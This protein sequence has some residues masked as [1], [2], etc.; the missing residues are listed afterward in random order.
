MP[1]IV[2]ASSKGGSGKSTTVFAL[3]GAFVEQGLSVRIVDADRAARLVDCASGG[4]LPDSVTV[5][6]A[7]ENNVDAA[8]KEGRGQADIVLVDVEGS[9]NAAILTAVGFAN[10]VVVPA[11]PSA[12]DVAAALETVKLI[13][14]VGSMRERPVNFGLLWTR[15]PT[16]HSKEIAAQEEDI[17]DADIPILGRLY[18]RTAYKSLFSYQRLLQD[19]GAAA[20]NLIKT[21]AEVDLVANTIL[22]AMEAGATAQGAAA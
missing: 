20:P 7:D 21:K 1:V 17:R 10:Y 11:N 16:T 14:R 22:D 8:I 19:L 13:R 3:T 4:N 6:A 2:V 12:M 9:A 5:V 18:E 15:V